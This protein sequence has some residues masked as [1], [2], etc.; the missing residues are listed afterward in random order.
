MKQSG[1]IF[2]MILFVL[3][4]SFSQP[5]LSL[6]KLEVNL[7]TIYS[8]M[9]KKGKIVLT[10]IGN[11]TLRIYSVEPSCG[12]TTI[13]RPKDILLP[14]ES[15]TVEVEFN[16]SGYHGKV[17]KH[18]SINSN[19]RLSENVSVKLIAEV[20]EE[21]ESI[22]HS[23]FMWLG[24]ISLGKTLMQGTSLKNIS[25]HIIKIKNFATS[26]STIT[27]KIE[28][29]VLNPND[30]LNVQVTVKPEKLGYGS[31]HFT[32]EIDSKNQPQIEIKISY[33]CVKEN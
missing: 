17:E 6:D 11:D 14:S 21:L 26:A 25:D 20:K 4:V 32:I 33:V 31:D 10:N 8:G 12:C 24:N 16:S 23:M 5:K 7:G 19:D 18:I 13:K 9:K 1:S 2:T 29:K 27:I 28:K 3:G 15:D 22:S 30:T